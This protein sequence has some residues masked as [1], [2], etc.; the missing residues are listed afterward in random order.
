MTP[1]TLRY[2]VLLFCLIAGPVILVLNLAGRWLWFRPMPDVD[3]IVVVSSIGLTNPDLYQLRPDSTVYISPYLPMNAVDRI[4]LAFYPT[5]A[6]SFSDPVEFQW[7][8]LRLVIYRNW[9]SQN[10]GFP[11]DWILTI[12]ENC[13]VIDKG[14]TRPYQPSDNALLTPSVYLQVESPQWPA[15]MYGINGGESPTGTISAVYID[16]TPPE[17]LR[18]RGDAVRNIIL[19]AV[20][21]IIGLFYFYGPRRGWLKWRE[22]LTL[23]KDLPL[24]ES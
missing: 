3:N 4:M 8:D 9:K 20:M 23:P 15:L 6:Y 17:I 22:G 18:R 10:A 19:G 13:V 1:A 16:P 11:P 14:R 5:R 21:T 24:Q 12:D 7:Q 2:S